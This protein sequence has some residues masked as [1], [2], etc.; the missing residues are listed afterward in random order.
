MPWRTA[1]GKGWTPLLGC[2]AR[3][4]RI[5]LLLAPALAAAC[6]LLLLSSPAAAQPIAPPDT[7]S[8]GPRPPGDAAFVRPPD[9][10]ASVFE[11]VGMHGFEIELGGGVQFGGADSPVQA[12]T[13]WG[14]GGNAANALTPRG[15]ILDPQGATTIGQN[16][17][18]YGIE[19]LA[20]HARVGYRYRHD[21]T[22]GVFF[23]YAQYFALD[24]ADAGDAPDFTSALTREQISVGA[25][26]RYYFTQL[27]RRFHPWVSLGVGYNYDGASYTRPI[28]DATG[29]QSGQPETGNYILQQ[30]G[31]IVP[32]AIGLDIRLAPIFSLGPELGYSHVFPIRSCVEV[33]VDQYSPLPGQ[34]TCNSPPVQSNG[35]DNFYGGIFAK[36]TFDPFAR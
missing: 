10:P 23:S 4:P 20:F 15:A 25:Y 36:V 1:G 27:H 16:F 9:A 8:Y 12:P 11:A 7:T 6:G 3:M 30:D 34:N 24:G 14:N 2:A 18:P 28:G 21:L 29:A 5:T 19:P 26:A 31:I 22:F 35:Y 13:L 33:D 32:V 17:D